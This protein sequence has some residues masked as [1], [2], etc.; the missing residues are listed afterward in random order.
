M[1][2]KKNNVDHILNTDMLATAVSNIE[3]KVDRNIKSTFSFKGRKS[4]AIT[5]AVIKALTKEGDKV[6]DPFLGSGTTIL[7]TQKIKRNLLGIELDNY[8]Y[9][10][11]KQ[12]FENRDMAELDEMF[13]LVEDRARDNVQSLYETSCCGEKNY[14]LK[15]LFDPNTSKGDRDGYFNPESNREIKDG[16]NVK[17]LNVCPVCGNKSK[18][19]SEDDWDK[20]SEIDKLD[21]SDFPNDKYIENSRINITASTG[22]DFY[23][24]I[25]TKR[26]KV[27]LLRLQKAITSLPT[28]DEKYFLQ[29]VLVSSLKLARTA[30]YGSSTDILYH[31][32]LEKAQEMNVWDLF[33]KQYHKFLQ[34][35]EKYQYAQ[36]DSF[37]AGDTYSVVND[38]YA[39]YLNNQSPKEKYDLI[40]TDFPYTDQV[41][42]LERNQLF[43]IWLNHFADSPDIYA[44]TDYMLEKEIVVSNAP[45][46]SNKNM[47]NFYKDVD[48]MFSVLGGHLDDYKPLVFFIKLGKKKYFNVFANIIN[49]ARKNGFEYAARVG[50]EK[51]DPTLR[52]QSA[53]NN[54]LIDEVL[55]GFVK[56]PED[57]KYLFLDK[58]NYEHH[59]V[60]IIYTLIKNNDSVSLS[61]GLVAI[62]EDLRNNRNVLA[63][64][65][66][67]QKVS[68]I[69]NENFRISDNQ[70]LSLSNTILYIDQEE[71]DK[72]N[73]FSKIYNLIPM[74]IDNL[75]EKN[76]GRFVLEDLYVE[77]VDNLT[78]GTTS[79]FNEL[80][81]ESN[82]INM[83]VQL[84][85]QLCDRNDKY[86]IPL[87][88]ADEI[89]EDAIDIIKM[90][91]YDF[92]E[93][94]KRLLS[95]EGFTD[96]IR[97]GGS[98]DLGV[99]LLAKKF[100]GN[101]EE[102]W[103]VQCKRWVNNVDATPLQRLDSERARLTADKVECI[104]TSH[105][106][107]DAQ[108]IAKERKVITTNGIDLLK[109]LNKQ[110]PGY[111]FN[112]LLQ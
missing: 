71:N 15:T 66:M 1:M 16:K 28:S 12:L 107:R 86:Y 92:E 27:A 101:S 54:T 108:S 82:N 91:P 72:E 41:P 78:D 32:V 69:I 46:R 67:I 105:Y 102:K 96:V 87:S 56:L 10:V 104:T 6:L 83:I 106:T 75:F 7:A 2:K 70:E 38:D 112:S 42:Y 74:F 47:E 33:Q 30:M 89:P 36:T 98:G 68:K 65:E 14:I 109:R 110:F 63:D 85:N 60:E 111:Y 95:K 64:N 24:K 97:K 3:N 99:D 18:K 93:L 55:V 57:E 37:I 58:V 81:D 25:F 4:A 62:K 79:I 31:V 77:L 48:Q 26:N 35:K 61:E 5:E 19:F 29:H 90:D 20:L 53:F 88:L 21:V 23:G 84:L 22:A 8:T 45:T 39:S 80:L 40:F 34:F 76:N 100:N 50:V 103:L 59:I 17:L 44:L 11:T 49:S 43:R 94:C 51:N 52:K 73:L 13:K 9:N